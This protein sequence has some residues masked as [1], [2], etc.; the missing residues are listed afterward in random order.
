MTNQQTIQ[1]RIC[2]HGTLI[3]EGGGHYC[4]RCGATQQPDL[5]VGRYDNGSGFME[6]ATQPVVTIPR[7]KK[8]L[9]AVVYR[10]DSTETAMDVARVE[11]DGTEIVVARWVAP[12][13]E[14]CDV[15]GEKWCDVAG[16]LQ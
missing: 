7:A 1:C 5:Y 12:L 14:W 10:L 13:T 9:S 15:A 3:F 11:L 4:D 6:W 2:D 16:V 8:Q